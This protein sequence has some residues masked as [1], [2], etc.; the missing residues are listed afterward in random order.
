MGQLV[1]GVV[2]ESS[3]AFKS[4][5]SVL[6]KLSQEAEMR[7]GRRLD[8]GTQLVSVSPFQHGSK[9]ENKPT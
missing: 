6:A 5:R 1:H 4:R 7:S 9:L 2:I 8:P 3:T